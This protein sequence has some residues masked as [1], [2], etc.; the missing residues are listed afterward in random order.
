MGVDQRVQQLVGVGDPS[1]PGCVLKPSYSQAVQLVT[2]DGTPQSP[3]PQE[4]FIATAGTL[5]ITDQ[6]GNTLTFGSLPIGTRIPIRAAL[7]KATGT[8]AV[9]IGLYA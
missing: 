4:L 2:S 5:V 1:T 3:T 9:V 6:F 7:V 8:T